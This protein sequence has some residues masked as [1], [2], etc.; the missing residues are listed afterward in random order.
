MDITC[1]CCNRKVTPEEYK[2]GKVHGAVTHCKIVILNGHEHHWV[3]IQKAER[4]LK[5]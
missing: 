3:N 1:D 2:R 4:I 5:K